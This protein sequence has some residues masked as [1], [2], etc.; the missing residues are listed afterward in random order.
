MSTVGAGKTPQTET[1][2]EAVS[3]LSP[4]LESAIKEAKRCWV[5]HLDVYT[6]ELDKAF[7]FGG[8]LAE[9]ERLAGSWKAFAKDALPQ[10]CTIGYSMAKAYISLHV[11]QDTIR[12]KIDAM[13]EEE[14]VKYYCP[15]NALRLVPAQHK[16][17]KKR[18][19]AK[20]KLTKKAEVK[21]TKLASKHN[22]SGSAQD[23][24]ALLVEC[25]LPRPQWLALGCKE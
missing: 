13:P 24:L 7:E 3:S 17:H 20:P 23:I 5:D 9:V 16:P 11:H 2:K 4:T 8:A 22:V 25:G 15:T 21:L 19:K 12:S 14:R 1:A 6:H 18:A 10:V